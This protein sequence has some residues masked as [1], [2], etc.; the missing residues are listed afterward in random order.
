M[1]ASSFRNFKFKKRTSNFKVAGVPLIPKFASEVPPMF[2]NFGIGTPG[3]SQAPA[4][5]VILA[6][7]DIVKRFET[8]D[9]VLTAVD[10]VSFGVA[11]GEF[12]WVIGP[13]GCGKSTLFYVIGGRPHGYG[14]SGGGAGE[15][16][17][18]P[19]PAFGIV[20]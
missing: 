4:A 16:G 11:P 15:R 17:R 1:A 19:H 7:D 13:S 5:D 9:G 12:V 6:V 3:M 14:G 20:L 10:H 8:A 2:A 18:G